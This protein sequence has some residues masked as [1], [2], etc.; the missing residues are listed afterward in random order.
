MVKLTVVVSDLHGVSSRQIMHALIG[1]CRDPKA[2][3]TRRTAR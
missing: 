3:P 2:S 1:G